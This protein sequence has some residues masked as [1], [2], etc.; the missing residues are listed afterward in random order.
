MERDFEAAWL[1][2]CIDSQSI[3][4]IHSLIGNKTQGQ[5]F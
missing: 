3:L 1:L 2:W 5:S 4:Q